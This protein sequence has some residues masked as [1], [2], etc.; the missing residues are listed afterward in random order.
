LP[1]LEVEFR[2]PFAADEEQYS[3]ALAYFLAHKYANAALRRAIAQAE[4]VAMTRVLAE[5][6]R[7]DASLTSRHGEQLLGGWHKISAET[8]LNA[9]RAKFS[10]PILRARLLALPRDVPFQSSRTPWLARMLNIVR[11]E[12]LRRETI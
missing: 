6:R 10:N 2:F 12:I 3:S 9:Q 11:A 7:M 8:M 4:T 5:T 1:F